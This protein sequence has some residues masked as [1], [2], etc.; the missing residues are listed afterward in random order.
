MRQGLKAVQAVMDGA[1]SDLDSGCGAGMLGGALMPL[2][3][4]GSQARAQLRQLPLLLRQRLRLGLQ[5]R[6]IF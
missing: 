1:F 2:A 5:N 3:L 4:L 6:F